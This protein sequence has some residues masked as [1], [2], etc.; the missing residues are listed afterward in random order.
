[1]VLLMRLILWSALRGFRSNFKAELSAREDSVA[2]LQQSGPRWRRQTLEDLAC[3]STA[4]F[5]LWHE[6]PDSTAV[7]DLM[8][9]FDDPRTF[10]VSRQSCFRAWQPLIL[11]A[12][13]FRKLQP[14]EAS[15]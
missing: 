13:P 2:S 4:R 12:A 14:G 1:A 3:T 10:A 6:G 15:Q 8:P 7:A 11:P 5:I 9:L